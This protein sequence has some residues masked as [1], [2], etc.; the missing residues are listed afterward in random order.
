MAIG[1]EQISY[2]TNPTFIVL[3]LTSVYSITVMLSQA[4][5]MFANREKTRELMKFLGDESKSE[6]EIGAFAAA[7]KSPHR[8]MILAALGHTGKA[9]E[10]LIALLGEEVKALRW[11]AEQR[12]SPLGTIA[13]VAPFIGLFGTVVGVIHAFHAISLKMGAGPSVVAGGIAEALISTAAGLFV[14]I[15]AVVAFNYFLKQARRLSIELERVAT[16]MIHRS[17]NK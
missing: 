14:A 2:L 3:L 4:Y 6:K 7:G 1:K 10:T 17:K 15:P 9:E 13:N 8:R 12:L 16:L 5:Y 11:E